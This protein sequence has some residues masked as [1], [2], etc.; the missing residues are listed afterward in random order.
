MQRDEEELPSYPTDEFIYDVDDTRELDQ[1]IYDMPPPASRRESLISEPDLSE[2][3]PHRRHTEKPDDFTI[4][5]GLW[6]Q[7]SGIT[8]QNYVSLLEVLGLLESISQLSN[9]PR[10]VSTLKRIVKASLPLIRMKR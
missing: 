1:G 7:D 5:F 2:Y 10:S 8:R 3:I 9:L 6:C 4:A